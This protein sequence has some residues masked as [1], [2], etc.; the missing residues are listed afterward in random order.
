MEG[1]PVEDLRNELKRA[2]DHIYYEIMEFQ[3]RGNCDLLYMKTKANWIGHILLTNCLVKH[4]VEGKVERS[5]GKMR[6][7]TKQLLVALKEKR[8]YWKLKE[9]ALY[10]TIWRTC[11]GRGCGP[12]IRQTKEL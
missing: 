2:T 8:G 3:R 4:T 10:C 5:A 9:A 12:V 6:K 7:K 1:K 11:F